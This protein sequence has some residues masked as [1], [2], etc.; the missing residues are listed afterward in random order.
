M[1]MDNGSIRVFEGFRVQYNHARGPTKG[2]IRFHPDETFDTVRALRLDDVEMRR[3]RHPP[4]GRQRRRG[5]QSQGAL[6]RGTRTPEPRLCPRLG[7]VH[8]PRN[9]RSRARRLYDAADHGMDDGRVR[10]HR[11]PPRS[12]SH[13]RQADRGRGLGGKV[14]FHRTRGRVLHPG[15]GEDHR[16]G[17]HQGYRRHPRLRQRWAERPQALRIALRYEDRGSLGLQ[18][19]VYAPNGLDYE[20]LAAHKAKDRERNGLRGS[21]G[22]SRTRRFSKYKPISS[23]PQRWR[24]SSTRATPQRQSEDRRA[25]LANGPTTPEGDDILYRNGVTSSLTSSATPAG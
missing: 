11:R 3:R 12:R 22:G 14:G 9:R 23:S 8:R 1:R 6:P 17:S 4:S 25:E 20:A 13:H 18:G 5:L 24:R 19:R 21:E 15:G 10:E 7:Q 2:G 16:H